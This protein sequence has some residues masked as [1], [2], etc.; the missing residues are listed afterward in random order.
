[1]Q[2]EL[3]KVLKE[4][5]P[6][7]ISPTAY[8]TA[9]VARLVDVDRDLSNRALEWLTEHQLADGSWGAEVPFYYHDRVISTLAAMI[10]LMHRGRRARDRQQIDDGLFALERITS[11]ATRGLLADPNG[12]TAGFEMIVPTLLAEAENMGIIKRQGDRILGRLAA[13]R[14]AKLAVLKNRKIDRTM[15]ASFSAEM[16]GT[17]AQSMLDLNNLQEADGSISH[18][19]SA[20]AYYLSQ[21]RPDDAAALSYLRNVVGNDGGTPMAMPFEICERAWVLWNISFLTHLDEEVKALCQPHLEALKASWKPLHGVGFTRDH[22][23]TDGD[24]TSLTFD[25]LSRFGH[26][27][28]FETLLQ[29]EERDHFRCYPLEIT[30]SVSTNVH[31]LGALRQMNLKVNHPLVQKVI[32]YLFKTRSFDAFWFDKWQTSPLYTTAHTIMICSD[33][34]KP[35]IE[36]SVQWLLSKQNSDGSWGYYGVPTAEE[37]AYALQAL[38]VWKRNGGS[39]ALNILTSGLNWL[40]E[41]ADSQ[42]IELF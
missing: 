32:Q 22:S 10:A 30:N 6:G 26:K 1:V 35:L 36:N 25:V 23:V 31:F 4:H 28:D 14:E 19:P 13:Q 37:T 11:D 34:Y 18:S 42:I 41:H 21:I 27:M 5:G 20:T 29:F 9:W 8:D 3:I 15:T 33:F 17:D 39:V 40:L 16:A 7:R 12:A 24:D 2:T 38:S